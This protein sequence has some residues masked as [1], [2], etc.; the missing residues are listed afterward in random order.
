MVSRKLE[1]KKKLFENFFLQRNL[2]RTITNPSE[3]R[4]YYFHFYFLDGMREKIFPAASS[5]LIFAL[6][7]EARLMVRSCRLLCPHF[8]LPEQCWRLQSYPQ[9]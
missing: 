9:L 8:L 3:S 2:K 7:A 1:T 5:Q 4:A 6:V